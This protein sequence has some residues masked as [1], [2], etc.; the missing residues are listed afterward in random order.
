MGPLEKIQDGRHFQDGRYLLI[1]ISINDIHFCIVRV[2][3][4]ICTPV[5]KKTV[6]CMRMTSHVHSRD[7]MNTGWY[8]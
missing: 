7:C 4:R 6:H 1:N 3:N 5:G 8:I 2:K